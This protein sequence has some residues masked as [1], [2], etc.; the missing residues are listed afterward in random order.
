MHR[1][2]QTLRR[3]ILRPQA[4]DYAHGTTGDEGEAEHLALLREKIEMM[5]GEEI[6]EKVTRVGP[7]KALEEMGATA[8]ELATLHKEDPETFEKFKESQMA[9][10]LNQSMEAMEKPEA[11]S[12]TSDET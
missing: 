12:S 2:G 7:D 9:M 1:F 4:L 10:R 5:R 6:R 8:E 3:D 11:Q